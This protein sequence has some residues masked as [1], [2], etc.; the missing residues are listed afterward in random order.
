MRFAPPSP[1]TVL[2]SRPVY[3]RNQSELFG[4]NN[5]YYNI[6]YYVMTTAGRRVG[7]YGKKKYKKTTK[8][9]NNN[10]NNNNNGTDT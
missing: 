2:R 4:R 10:N 9:S 8:S 3:K 1:L 7:E 5:I 6:S